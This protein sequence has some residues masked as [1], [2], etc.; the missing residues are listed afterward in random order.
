MK[1][2]RMSR[3]GLRNCTR[4]AFAGMWQ[5]EGR[6]GIWWYVQGCKADH[7]PENPRAAVAETNGAFAVFLP[8]DVAM[9]AVCEALGV[10][11]PV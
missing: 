1:A 4:E 8:D 2:K 7:V 10:N 11:P 3:P 9:A 5:V 6:P